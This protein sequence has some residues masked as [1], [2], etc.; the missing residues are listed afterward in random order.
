M[1]DAGETVGTLAARDRNGPSA[2][3]PPSVTARLTSLDV[4]A[5][6]LGE[7]IGEVPERGLRGHVALVGA[8]HDEHVAVPNS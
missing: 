2:C 6:H 3:Q 4:A 1:P 5:R 7:R 8:G